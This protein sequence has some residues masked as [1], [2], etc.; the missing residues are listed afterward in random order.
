[1][2]ESI[3]FGSFRGCGASGFDHILLS[4]CRTG[5]QSKQ[6]SCLECFFFARLSHRMSL[7]LG[8]AGQ[9]QREAQSSKFARWFAYK[10]H[11]EAKALNAWERNVDQVNKA[12]GTIASVESY[13]E[14]SET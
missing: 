3:W 14:R 13:L 10:Q 12:I 9:L 4:V 1:M 2:R 5:E 8:S 11:F 7:A 6:G